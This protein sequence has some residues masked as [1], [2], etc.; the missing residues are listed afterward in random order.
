MTGDGIPRW[1][2]KQ[3]R[4]EL[5]N[6]PMNEQKRI[7]Q[8][9]TDRTKR[10]ALKECMVPG[11]HAGK[12]AEGH[13]IQE[14]VMRRLTSR[15]MIMSFACFPIVLKRRCPEEVEI[16]HA[17]TGYFACREHENMFAAVENNIPNFA[18]EE[19]LLLLA[20][21]ALLK[22]TW[23]ARLMRT[24]WNAMEAEDP[25]SDMPNYMAR[26]HKEMEEGVGYY[27]Y[28]AEKMLGIAEHPSPYQS[29]PNVLKHIVVR[30][31]SRIPTIA[32]SA[33]TD[34]L[35]FRVTPT[36]NG[37]IVER[38]VQWGCTVYPM[39]TEHIV[40]YHFPASDELTIRN[41]TRAVRLA[42]DTVL[43]RKVSQQLLGRIEDI[44]IS[45]EVWESFTDDKRNTIREYFEATTPDMGIRT[46]DILATVTAKKL[47]SKRLRLVNLFNGDPQRLNR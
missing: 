46:P 17:M 2:G 34:G 26:L 27:K 41:R 32:A 16:H 6:M 9:L 19:H 1:F 25:E 24:A 36:P 20:Y 3:F 39:K 8:V 42:N 23:D 47:R 14:A 7:N 33:W 38:L 18:D 21:K 28:V 35:G 43:Q 37:P 31:P 10:T 44:A 4:N 5:V 13:N 40:V 12:I 30:V 15:T 22:G 11:R 45:P 29:V